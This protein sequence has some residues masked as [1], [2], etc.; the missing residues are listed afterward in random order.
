MMVH[1]KRVSML[2]AAAAFALAAAAEVFAH[3]PAPAADTASV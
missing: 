3:L 1:M 2:M